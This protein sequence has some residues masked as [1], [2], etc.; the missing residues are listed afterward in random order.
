[1]SSF[2]V[3]MPFGVVFMALDAQAGLSG[4]RLRHMS[5]AFPKGGGVPA[6]RKRG[7]I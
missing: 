5:G 7:A 3:S 6:R 4:V 1:M 2:F